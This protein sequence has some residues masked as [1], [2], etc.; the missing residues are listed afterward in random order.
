MS[1]E[2]SV[3]LAVE[4]GGGGGGGEHGGD[5]TELDV[6]EFGVHGITVLPPALR[7]LDCL[8]VQRATALH[9]TAVCCRVCTCNRECRVFC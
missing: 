9:L 7:C 6:V 8:L 2:N 5:S 4:F 3:M 1:S